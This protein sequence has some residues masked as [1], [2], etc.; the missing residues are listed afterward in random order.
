MR[1]ISGKIGLR[2][3]VAREVVVDGNNGAGGKNTIY[4]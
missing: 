2:E 4:R 1:G 3:K